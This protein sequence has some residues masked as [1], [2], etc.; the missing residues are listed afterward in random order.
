[1][2]DGRGG[3]NR[4]RIIMFLL[5]VETDADDTLL[6]VRDQRKREEREEKEHIVT[7]HRNLHLVDS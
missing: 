2:R 1:M 4:H 6:S 5:Q 7:F 3:D